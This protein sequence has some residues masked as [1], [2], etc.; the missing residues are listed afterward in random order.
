MT[1]VKKIKERDVERGK[2]RKKLWQCNR[3]KKKNAAKLT[4]TKMKV[5]I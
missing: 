3:K 2:R 1:V 5:T 4:E